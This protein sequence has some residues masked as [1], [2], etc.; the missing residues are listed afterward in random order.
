MRIKGISIFITLVLLGTGIVALCKLSAK[1]ESV[2][3]FAY[4]WG[5]VRLTE[6]GDVVPDGMY[7]GNVPRV[8]VIV[9]QCIGFTRPDCFHQRVVEQFRCEFPD[10]DVA[11][12]DIVDYVKHTKYIVSGNLVP[13]IRLCVQG[14]DVDLC[15]KISNAYLH[16]I[17]KEVDQREAETTRSRSDAQKATRGQIHV[18]RE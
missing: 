18:I 9:D 11:D 2:V 3:E 10:L 4:W 13:T 14:R 15:R 1:H 7:L 16:A 5:N 17:V 6:N 8:D 12:S